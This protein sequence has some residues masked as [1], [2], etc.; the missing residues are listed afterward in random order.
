MMIKSR[1]FR[2]YGHKQRQREKNGDGKDVFYINKEKRQETSEILFFFFFFCAVDDN[3]NK[4]F[5][6]L[7]F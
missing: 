1:K 2:S 5:L 6:K 3:R 4:I 7:M